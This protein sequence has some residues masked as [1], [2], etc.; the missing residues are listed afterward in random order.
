MVLGSSAFWCSPITLLLC[1]FRLF[2]CQ[3]LRPEKSCKSS[4]CGKF[5]A[6]QCPQNSVIRGNGWTEIYVV[7]VTVACWNPILMANP[8]SVALHPQF[9]FLNASFSILFPQISLIQPQFSIF[10]SS[11]SIPGQDKGIY[12]SKSPQN[13]TISDKMHNF[14]CYQ[15]F[16]SM[17]HCETKERHKNGLE[18]PNFDLG[19]KTVL[20]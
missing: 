9:S 17:P 16:L 10:D 2:R 6:L 13:S 15:L 1:N 14:Y 3:Q 4:L 5:R 8:P 12:D 11:S 7:N 19:L 18:R 20:V